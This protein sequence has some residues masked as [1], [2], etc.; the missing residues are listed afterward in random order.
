MYLISAWVCFFF[1]IFAAGKWH[2]HSFT[3]SI[4]IPEKKRGNCKYYEILNDVMVIILYS[5][6]ADVFTRTESIDE[7]VA[8]RS[9]IDSHVWKWAWLGS[10]GCS[11]WF[12]RFRL[13]WQIKMAAKKA[14]D[15][16]PIPRPMIMNSFTSLSVVPIMIRRRRLKRGHLFSR[17]RK[18]NRYC[19]AVHVIN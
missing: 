11:V 18:L 19:A 16:M 6:A 10:I 4:V 5:C 14:M 8:N 12:F 17:K 13:R 7:L 1:R 9:P 3:I 15:R 2:S